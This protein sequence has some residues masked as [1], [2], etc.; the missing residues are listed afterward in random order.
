VMDSLGRF[1]SD[2]VEI[3][4]I[5]S[6]VGAIT[7]NDV[8][9]AAASDAVVVGFSVRPDSKAQKAAQEQGVELKSFRI[10]YELIDEV[11]DLLS[12]MLSPE[13]R[14]EDQGKAE[15]RQTFR[16]PKAGVIAGC[17]VT[18]GRIN[19]RDFARLVRDGRV[20]WEGKLS[21]LRRFKDD[22][23]EVAEGYECGIGLTKF[24]D[25]HIGDIIEVYTLVE[26]ARELQV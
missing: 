13:V 12:G 16:V 6:G 11:R 14:E 7:E 15:V 5:H 23:R 10:I 24:D 1:E 9:L 19:R 18:Q 22:V 4:I 3:E 20:V 2:E 17:Y 25:I 8:Q 21:S 26:E